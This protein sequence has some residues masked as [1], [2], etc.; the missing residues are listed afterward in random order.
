MGRTGDTEIHDVLTLDDY[1]HLLGIVEDVTEARSLAELCDR[2]DQALARRFG[3]K[4]GFDVTTLRIHPAD[5][6][7]AACARRRAISEQLGLLLKP[8]FTALSS[9]PSSTPSPPTRP[10]ADLCSL[11]TREREVM[12]LVADGLTNRQIA[13]RL[14][15]AVDTVK[16]HLTSAMTKTDCTNRTQLALLWRQRPPHVAGPP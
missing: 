4:G 16:K 1:R 15:I 7:E 12:R 8:W 5:E 10:P 14:G 9:T 11:T 13:T 6:G 3:W 2:V